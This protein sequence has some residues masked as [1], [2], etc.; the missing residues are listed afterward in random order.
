MK[1]PVIDSIHMAADNGMHTELENIARINRPAE[2][3]EIN[4]LAELLK[5]LNLDYET[6][7]WADFL[8]VKLRGRRLISAELLSEWV[9]A[10]AGGGG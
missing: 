7:D 4:A 1:T 2:W 5:P 10:Q 8:S 6:S 9:R 3:T